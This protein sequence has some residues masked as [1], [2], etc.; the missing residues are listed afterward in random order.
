MFTGIVEEVG[1]VTSISHNG[2]TVRAG[3]V[4]SDLKLGR[5]HRGEWRLSDGRLHR[6][7]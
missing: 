5:Q 2:M 6:G 7:F 4:M 3:T 1:A